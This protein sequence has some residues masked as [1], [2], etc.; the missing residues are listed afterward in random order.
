M[1]TRTRSSCVSHW[2]DASSAPVVFNQIHWHRYTIVMHLAEWLDSRIPPVRPMQ[3]NEAQ[4]HQVASAQPTAPCHWSQSPMRASQARVL[5]VK[6][7]GQALFQSATMFGATAASC[8]FG[9]GCYFFAVH[10][11][12]HVLRSGVVLCPIPFSIGAMASTTCSIAQ[13]SSQSSHKQS[14]SATFTMLWEAAGLVVH[15]SQPH[16]MD[17]GC[18]GTAGCLRRVQLLV[19]PYPG[20]PS[21]GGVSADFDGHWGCICIAS[22]PTRRD[23]A[24]AFSSCRC[25]TSASRHVKED[26]EMHGRAQGRLEERTERNETA[27]DLLLAPV[28][29]TDGADDGT[30]MRMDAICTSTHGETNTF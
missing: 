5:W 19:D 9:T 7:I 6:S 13:R 24:T 28:V 20:S 2:H 27:E 4:I 15:V 14:T 16:R 26:M 10:P 1:G 11:L 25:D 21:F 29:H 17:R 12:F 22:R 23:D 30:P 8:Y 18:T 3:E